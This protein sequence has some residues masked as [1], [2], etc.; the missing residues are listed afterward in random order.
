MSI[1]IIFYYKDGCHLCEDMG[2]ALE[3]FIN[4]HRETFD[5]SVVMRDI[6]DS[7]AWYER[8]RE[9]VPVLEVGGEEVCHYFMDQA[10][11]MDA[12]VRFGS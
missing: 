8:Y 9:Y 6:E 10:E 7:A 3:V 5:F 11:L 4:E 1:E 2:N 12:I